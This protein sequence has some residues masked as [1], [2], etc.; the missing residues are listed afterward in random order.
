M[1]IAIYFIILSTKI[2]LSFLF[3]F[4][5]NQ[6]KKN[7]EFLTHSPFQILLQKYGFGLVDFP[8]EAIE[9]FKKIV[10]KQTFTKK[11]ILLRKGEICHSI[12]F[13]E[14]G[15]AR[16]YFENDSVELTSD[17]TIDGEI[18]VA[19]SSFVSQTPSKETIE[20]L[21]DSTV[22]AIQYDDLQELYALFPKLERI[23]RKVA[24]YHYNS[25]ANHTYIMKFLNSTERYQ[26]LFNYKIE[27]IKRTPIGIIA[28]YLGMKIETLSR[29]RKQFDK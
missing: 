5:K 8:N 29:I 10:Q 18:L 21:E 11:N 16:N 28:S 4:D 3:T 19:F 6:R 12:Y 17:I 22:F 15:L 14:K 9:K 23:G 1:I 27:V 25:L 13:L 24:E 2:N 7:L 26:Y 20:F